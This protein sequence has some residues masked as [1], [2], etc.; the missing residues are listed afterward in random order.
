MGIFKGSG[1]ALITPFNEDM[2]INY[3]KLEELIEWHI[4]NKT[5]ALIIA[6]TTGEASTL[7]DEEHIELV[8]RSVEIVR[9][10]IPVIAGSGSND[11]RHGIKLG[12]ECERAGA[13]G[14]LIVTPYYNKTNRQ[15]LINHYTAIADRVNIPIILYNVPGRTGMNI[16]VDVVVE[17]SAHKNIVGIK[18]ASGDISYLAEIARVC[19][20][21]FSIYSGN[22]DI[23]VPV[24]S[25]GGVGVISVLANVMPLETHNLVMSYLEG[26]LTKSRDLQLSLNA[27]V[28]SLFIET[29]PIP[30]KSAMN[31]MNLKV[32]GV[33]QPLW[34]MSSE[35]LELLKIE[36]GKLNL[37]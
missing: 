22:D 31:L 15:G 25:L 4:E 17:L 6:G 13:D 8:G 26:D 2:S 20:N 28:N 16:P 19:E 1:V 37:I 24:L 27:F 35:S 12:L 9:G 23:I 11:T 33:R 34:E 5:D 14:L 21:D 29:N 36:M 18:E 7:T 30:V 3:T 32:G 10:R